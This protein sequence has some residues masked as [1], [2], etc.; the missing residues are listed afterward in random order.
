MWQWIFVIHCHL[1][2]PS[3]VPTWPQFAVGLGYDVEW[4]GPRRVGPPDDPEPLQFRE[5]GLGC[6][7]LGLIEPAWLR[8]YRMALRLD[9]VF[10]LM[11]VL[12]LVEVG[13]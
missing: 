1:V 10:D 3:V 6:L 5:L 8:K 13:R 4:T 7:Q 9:V 12:P 11:L 2:E